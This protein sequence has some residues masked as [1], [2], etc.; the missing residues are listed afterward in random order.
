MRRAAAAVFSLG[1]GAGFADGGDSQAQ[2]SL[3]TEFPGA[4]GPASVQHA[5]AI[6]AN[7]NGATHSTGPRLLPPDRFGG[8]DN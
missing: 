6:A 1:I 7:Q 3:F 2:N 4:V 5:P 8:S